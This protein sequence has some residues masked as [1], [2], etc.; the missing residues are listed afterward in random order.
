MQ[1]IIK[2]WLLSIKLTVLRK[3]YLWGKY[4]TDTLTQQI[5]NIYCTQTMKKPVQFNM[6]TAYEL[7]G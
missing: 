1:L 3:Y 5:N 6:F 2:N 4:T 7:T